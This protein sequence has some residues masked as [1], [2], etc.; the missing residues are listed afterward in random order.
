M[1]GAHRE[2]NEFRSAIP[3]PLMSGMLIGRLPKS[4]AKIPLLPVDY[5]LK[6]INYTNRGQDKGVAEP[7][8]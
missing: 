3:Y 4:K 7:H 5:W 6:Y 8:L 2:Q 1:R